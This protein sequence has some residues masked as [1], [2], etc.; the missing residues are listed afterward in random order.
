MIDLKPYLDSAT[1]ADEKVQSIIGEM[2]AAFNDG[3]DEGKL[4]A[5]ELKPT[6][7]EAK[8]KA[9]QANELY[10]SIR[11]A[12]LTGDNAAS[13]FVAAQGTPVNPE[14]AAGK[15]MDRKAFTALNAS[16][17]MKFIQDGGKVVDPE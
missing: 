10:V 16:A 8:E 15:Q 17:R 2:D 6:L 12:S 9:K 4:K 5:L 13:N 3:T 1:K 7:D 14:S 11:D